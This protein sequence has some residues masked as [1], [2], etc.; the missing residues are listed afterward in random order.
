MGGLT[1]RLASYGRFSKTAGGFGLI[2]TGF[3][4]EG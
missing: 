3:G 4:T 2:N 1:A